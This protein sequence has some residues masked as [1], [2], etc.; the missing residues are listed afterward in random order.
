MGDWARALWAWARQDGAAR[1]LGLLVLIP[2]LGAEQYGAFVAL[3][4]LM[5][6]VTALAQSG[7]PLTVF[8]HA[9][10]DREPVSAVARSCLSL[11]VMVSPALVVPAAAAACQTCTW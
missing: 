9:V 1:G 3:F 11:A 10:R 5:G 4:A 6:P 8:E 7:V 2:R